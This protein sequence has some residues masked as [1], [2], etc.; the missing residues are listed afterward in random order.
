MD[1]SLL[2]R[3][4]LFKGMTEDELA[5][6]LLFLQAKVKAFQKGGALLHAGDFTDDLGLVLAGSVTVER[7]DAWGN[8]VI[9]G[10]IVPG[11]IFAG[12][13]ALLTD[14]PL[15]VDVIA[16][17]DCRVLF[18]HL[19]SAEA[20]AGCT[21]SWASRFTA[22]LLTVASRKILHLAGRSFHT[23]P[24]TVRG[25]VMAYLNAVSLQAQSREFTIPFDRQQLADYLNVERTALSKE[26]GKMQKDGL[27]KTKK[28]HFVIL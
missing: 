20:L 13:Y 9:L 11:G 16:N 2:S 17:E 25:R 18:L 12:A 15:Q 28:N 19:G 7:H 26:L 24:K 21:A 14:E 27:I 10:Q 1:L 23:A 22:N 5:S 6:A 4:V 3:T 8:R